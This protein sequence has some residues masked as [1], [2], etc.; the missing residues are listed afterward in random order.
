MNPLG[1]I[2]RP[3]EIASVVAFLAGPGATF[4]TGQC[5]SADGGA[6]MH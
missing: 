4:I 5:F 1:R 6:A 3:E 2:G